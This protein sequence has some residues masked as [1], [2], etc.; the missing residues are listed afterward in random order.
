M[1]LKMKILILSLEL[2]PPSLLSYSTTENSPGLFCDRF[3]CGEVQTASRIEYQLFRHATKRA[4]Y[5]KPLATEQGLTGATE[6]CMKKLRR[7]QDLETAV[8]HN[9]AS[10][11]F[12]LLWQHNGHCSSSQYEALRNYV[13]LFRLH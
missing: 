9:F 2:K 5:Q 13:I 10:T 8:W 12:T 3:D 11:I 1:I 6:E 7:K 4:I